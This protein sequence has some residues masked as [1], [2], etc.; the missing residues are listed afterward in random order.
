VTGN[1]GLDVEIRGGLLNGDIGT[2]SS[3]M[4]MSIALVV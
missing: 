2:N 4:I 3:T 1:S